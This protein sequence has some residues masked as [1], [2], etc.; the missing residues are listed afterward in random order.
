MNPED[1]PISE[2]ISSETPVDTATPPIGVDI[3]AQGPSVKPKKSKTFP[4]IVGI[5]SLFIIGIG[6]YYVYDNYIKE[7]QVDDT[8]DNTIPEES[9]IPESGDVEED[10]TETLEDLANTYVHNEEIGEIDEEYIGSWLG[11]ASVGDSYCERYVLFDTGNYLYFPSE[12]EE[13]EEYLVEIGI[14]GVEEGE[15]N[16]VKEADITNIV[17]I[18]L[19]EI[20]YSPADESPYSLKAD[21]GETTYWLVSKETDIWN[22]STL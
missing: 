19:G 4:I 16:L 22:P 17:S 1:R 18:V 21:F 8:I 2:L 12:N 5:L 7:E 9:Q 14:W 15:L 10:D 13:A 11:C 6:G 20:E 3:E